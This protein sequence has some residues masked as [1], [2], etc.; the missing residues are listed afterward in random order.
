M[1]KSD[2]RIDLNQ[3]RIQFCIKMLASCL[4]SSYLCTVKRLKPQ[5]I[6]YKTS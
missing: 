3:K 2:T 5:T 1:K 6:R 4:K